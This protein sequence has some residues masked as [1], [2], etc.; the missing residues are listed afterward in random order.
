MSTQTTVPTDVYLH[1]SYRPDCDYIEG[2]VRE[3]NLGTFEHSK[4]QGLLAFRFWESRRD[5]NLLAVIG[6]RI[7][8]APERVRV[9]DVAVMARGPQPSVPVDPP[10]IAIEV[11]SP[12]DT[13]GDMIDRAADYHTMGVANIWLVDP[14]R[15]SGKIYRDKSWLDVSEFSVLDTP[16]RIGLTELFAEF[17]EF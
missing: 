8:V 5:W 15:R 13:Y 17:D 16:I 7:R 14:I 4:A 11:L 12:D 3:R 6:C 1:T 9:P 2:E 10:L